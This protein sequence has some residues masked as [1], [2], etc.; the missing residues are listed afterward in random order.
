MILK[1]QFG[2]ECAILALIL[3]F[4]CSHGGLSVTKITETAVP[5]NEPIFNAGEVPIVYSSRYKISLMGLEN[6]H[7]FDIGKYDK[8]YN[9]LI[10]DKVTNP[11]KVISPS[12]LTREQLLLIHT[13]DYLTSLE[14]P[15]NVAQYLEAPILKHLPRQSMKANVV[16][17]FILSSGGTL[18]A[19][20]LALKHGY[21]INLGGGYHHAKPDTGEGFCIIADVP[22]AIRQ[23]QKDKKINRALIIDTD[24]HQGNGTICCLKNDPTTYTFSM[25]QGGIY[26]TPKEKGD[27]DI[28]LAEGMGDDAYLAILKKNLDFLFTLSRPDIVFHVA[29]CDAL[30]GDPLAGLK[31]T[32]EGIAK[33][34]LMIATACAKH[35]VPYVM[36]LSGGYSK[37]AW[38]AQQLGISKVIEWAKAHPI[39]NKTR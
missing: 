12:S 2:I 15:T 31:M 13:E 29:G 34:D 14:D 20:E 36:T 17:R 18:R 39:K 19:A 21:A 5:I 11:A 6:L 8:I 38:K 7:P 22:I 26:P 35:K 24:V 4:S 16:D 10:T 23:L 33:R 1:L 25:H 32:H 3:T 28:E 9:K 27:L 37:G 30:D